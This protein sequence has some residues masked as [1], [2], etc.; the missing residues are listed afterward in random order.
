MPK[1]YE[2]GLAATAVYHLIEN[3]N[4]NNTIIASWVFLYNQKN[5]KEK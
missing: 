2:N 3:K 1:N 5:Y 4:I